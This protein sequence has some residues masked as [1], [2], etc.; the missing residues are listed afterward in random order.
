[1]SFA[2]FTAG[3]QSFHTRDVRTENISFVTRSHSQEDHGIDYT[4][5]DENGFKEFRGKNMITIFKL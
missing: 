5:R 3:E 4:V 1:L 2:L